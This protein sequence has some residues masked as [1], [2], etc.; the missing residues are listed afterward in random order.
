MEVHP[1]LAAHLP[2]VVLLVGSEPFKLQPPHPPLMIASCL[3]GFVLGVQ[4]VLKGI[5]K[6]G[7]RGKALSFSVVFLPS[8]VGEQSSPQL[9]LVKQNVGLAVPQC[10]LAGS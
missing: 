4:G 9:A 1:L 10:Y 8:C 6:T 7:E 3:L 5:L 2:F